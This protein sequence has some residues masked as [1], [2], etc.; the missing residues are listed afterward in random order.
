MTLYFLGVDASVQTGEC[1]A[2]EDG[3]ATENDTLNLEVDWPGTK[4]DKH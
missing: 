3:S 2:K 4:V 1:A